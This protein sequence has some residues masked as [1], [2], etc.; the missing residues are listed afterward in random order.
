MHLVVT[1]LIAL[2][3][4]PAIAACSTGDPGRAYDLGLDLA[5]RGVDTSAAREVGPDSA[6]CFVLGYRE[7]TLQRL[8]RTSQ[9]HPPQTV[10]RRPR[11]VAKG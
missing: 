4:F 3:A 1:A 10:L 6:T 11:N 7:G 9:P 5:F 8:L 2:T